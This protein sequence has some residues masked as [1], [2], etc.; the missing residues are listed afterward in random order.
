MARLNFKNKTRITVTKGGKKT[1][2]VVKD[3]KI[4]KSE[5]RSKLWDMVKALGNKS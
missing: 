4:Y 2:M 1:S 5:G 3:H